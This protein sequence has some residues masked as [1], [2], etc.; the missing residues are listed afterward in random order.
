MT[1]H[2]SEFPKHPL[3]HV[4]APHEPRRPQVQTP[5]VFVYEKQEWEYK[6]VSGI[7]AADP[8]AAERELNALGKD[9]WELVGI[10]NVANDVRLYLKRIRK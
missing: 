7:A 5:T 9:G 8:L 4:P 10:V 1:R 6:V 3:P 2:I